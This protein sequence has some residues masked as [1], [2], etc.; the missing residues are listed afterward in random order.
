MLSPST[1]LSTSDLKSISINNEDEDINNNVELLSENEDDEI[2][3]ISIFPSAAAASMLHKASPLNYGYKQIIKTSSNN[4][5]N[6]NGKSSGG[7]RMMGSTTG[8]RN[9]KSVE[10]IVVVI[11]VK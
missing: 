5:N 8:A 10:I 11:I 7:R 6:N 3:S 2:S 4:N 1:L 9:G